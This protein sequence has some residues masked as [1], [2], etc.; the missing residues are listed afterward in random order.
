MPITGTMIDINAICDGIAAKYATLTGLRG[1]SAD[2][3]DNVPATPWALVLSPLA[4]QIERPPSNELWGMQVDTV[5]LGDITPGWPR[6][7][8]NL[9][10]YVPLVLNAFQ[11]GFRLGLPGYVQ[12]SFVIRAAED[13]LNIAGGDYPCF[14]FTHRILIR[15]QVT[16]SG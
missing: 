15:Y 7:Y 13:R 3:Y 2:D 8:R 4:D 12:D 11:D 16:R 1:A 9:R 10:A 6:A 14:R 5:V